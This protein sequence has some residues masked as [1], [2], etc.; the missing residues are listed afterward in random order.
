M[1][2]VLVQTTRPAIEEPL[3]LF[4]SEAETPTYVTKSKKRHVFP[5]NQSMCRR[6]KTSL[7]VI[8]L[9]LFCHETREGVYLGI[10]KIDQ[11]P[12]VRHPLGRHSCLSQTPEKKTQG[13]S[14]AGMCTMRLLT[15]T[16]RIFALTILSCWSREEG[17]V[18]PTNGSRDREKTFRDVQHLSCQA[19]VAR[20]SSGSEVMAQS[21]SPL[22][23]RRAA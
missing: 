17:V 2:G 16:A 15:L 21:V 4:S 7:I 23:L 13:G 3:F 1:D 5:Q 19:A 14:Q 9:R 11:Y 20:F 8:S 18:R 22:L 12:L 10:V 6:W